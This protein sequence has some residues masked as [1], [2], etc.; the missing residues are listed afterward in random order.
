MRIILAIAMLVTTSLP[1]RAEPASPPIIHARTGPWQLDYDANACHLIGKFGR[2]EDGVI[3]RLTKFNYGNAFTLALI[4]KPVEVKT[5]NVTAK[6]DF[7]VTNGAVETVLQSGKMGALPALQAITWFGLR[8]VTANPTWPQKQQ[9][10]AWEKQRAETVAFA[11]NEKVHSLILDLPQ[12]NQ[13]QLEFGPM[14]K[15][16]AQVDLCL[17]DLIRSWGYDPG[18]MRTLSKSAE[19]ITSPG[20]WVTSND[21][22]TQA[23]RKGQRALVQFRLDVSAAGKVE[24][25][26]I[27]Q[28]GNPAEF[29]QSVCKLMMKRASFKPALDVVGKPIRSYWRSSVNFNL[30]Y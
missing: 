28:P 29:D 8:S 30:P 25:C 23:L 20:N 11:S 5:P 15:P 22:P 3:V 1:A 6:L 19:P 10:E 12:K 27:L 2:D 24:G 26:H 7:G 17:D 13:L 18:L 16:L 21:Y 14:A 4:G 9:E